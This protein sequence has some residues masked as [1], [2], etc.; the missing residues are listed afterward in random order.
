M[1]AGISI[2]WIET[3]EEPFRPE[4]TTQIFAELE[5]LEAEQSTF[6]TPTYT[7]FYNSFVQPPAV[8]YGKLPNFEAPGRELIINLETTTVNPWEGRIIAIGVLDPNALEPQAANFIQETEEATIDEFLIWFEASPFTTLVGYN[9]SFDY[10]FLYAVLQKYRKE[11]RKLLSMDLYDLM[12]QQKQVKHEFV[13]GFNKPGKLEE[14][15][16][17]L[18]G[19]VPYAD[20]KQVFKWFEEGN[21][22]EI[23]NFNS[24]KLAK[25][26]GLWVLNK[27]VEGTIPGAEI[28][29]RP[30][31]E[32]TQPQTASNPGNPGHET[33]TIPVKCKDCLQE[34][35]MP[36]TASVKDC[37]VCGSPIAHP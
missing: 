35:T 19:S 2:K 31:T 10:R 9:V 8:S 33:E 5:P 26:Y 29:A 16:T 14:W 18:F 23:V 28:L 6:F 30:S 7:D 17:Y 37:I 3:T 25:A 36:K 15:A 24:D 13:F 12:Q 11:S 1:Q 32:S 27:V 34:Q 4:Q 21:I 20:Q 22:E